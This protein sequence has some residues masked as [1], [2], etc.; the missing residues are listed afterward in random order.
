MDE[1]E[2]YLLFKRVLDKASV[3]FYL[4]NAEGRFGYVNPAAVKNL[5]Y[6]EE[7]LLSLHL[8][9]IDFKIGPA[10]PSCLHDLKEQGRLQFET[11]HHTK[12]G[13][14]VEKDVNAVYLT[15]GSQD[16][17]SVFAVDIS[18]RKQMEMALRESEERYRDLFESASDLIQI[19]R[20]D[21]RF[22]FVNPA[23]RATFGYSEDEVAQMT[24]FD[25]IDA[26]CA[27]H[28][29][30]TFQSVIASGQAEM[31][32]ANFVAKSG[33]KV[34]IKGSANCSYDEKGNPQFARCIFRNVTEEKKLQE[35]LLQAQKMEAVGRLTSGVAHD[36]NNLL[37]TILSYSE[38]YL[39]RL[40]SEDP[41]AEALRAIRDAGL[42]GAALTRQLLTFSR[43]QVVDVRVIDLNFALANMGRMILRL[44][45]PDIN[46]SVE[47]SDS[48]A[49]I[50]ADLHQIEQVVLNLAINARDAMPNG[51]KLTISCVEEV[52]EKNEFSKFESIEPG[53]Y[54]VLDVTDT[55]EG[56]SKSVQEQI[57]VPFFT[58]KAQGKGTGLGLATAYGIV[59]QHS[60]YIVVQSEVGAG[61]TFRIYF[62][63]AQAP[64]DAVVSDK[65]L[66]ALDG[67]ETI[68][69]VDDEPDI[70][71][72]VSRCLE[73]IGYTVLRA[74][75][76]KE[77]LEVAAEQ[78]NRID[79]LLTDV[80]M[81]GM[82]GHELVEKAQRI[83][84][85][86]KVLF[87][88]GYIDSMADGCGTSTAR[89]NFISKPLAP[90]EL[91]TKLRKILD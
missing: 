20:P 91:A 3:E 63:K 90:G 72:V 87:M 79:L 44:I 29:L 74:S 2:L 10:F 43:H 69:V 1:K 64:A 50:L 27:S 25:I 83:I 88:S 28:C 67:S 81:P 76:S 40:P 8:A 89:R 39:M 61:T 48:P 75:S 49:T 46:F 59:K 77:A 26:D 6:S 31:I 86:L 16:Y 60:G 53:H 52:L 85:G 15:F 84:P 5:G 54:V 32:E 17:V 65:V 18:E 7:E 14:V 38:L 13:R 36:F 12:D 62:P 37:T 70:L 73:P 11:T 9:D 33:E 55:G 68:L 19:V 58:T 82:N 42:R 47:V 35:Q 41:L 4:I 21:G 24:V 57:F 30:R 22:L 34:S 78:R 80:I 66:D 51:G 71:D 45:H 56:M 23:W